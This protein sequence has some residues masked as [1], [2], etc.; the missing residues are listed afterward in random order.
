MR[1]ID[2]LRYYIGQQANIMIADL[3]ILKQI[4]VKEFDNFGD[5]AV[6]Y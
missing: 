1:G 5:H 3:D 2:T 6:S 4:L